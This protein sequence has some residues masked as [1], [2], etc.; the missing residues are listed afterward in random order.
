MSLTVR[1]LAKRLTTILTWPFHVY[2]LAEVRVSSPMQRSLGRRAA[3]EGVSSVWGP[4]SP[5]TP[6]CSMAP[7]GVA[8]FAREPWTVKPE[9][10]AALEKWRLRSRLVVTRV[11]GPSKWNF[12]LICLY[13]FADGHPEKGAN[14]DLLPPQLS[15]VLHVPNVAEKMYQVDRYYLQCQ[16]SS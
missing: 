6:S 3:S 11:C 16:D 14:D 1:S 8:V 12:I 13:G 9:P 10:V 5:P 15:R 7:G 2:A 4:P